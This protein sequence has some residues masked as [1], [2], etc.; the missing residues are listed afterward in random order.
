MMAELWKM[1][2]EAVAEGSAQTTRPG[3]YRVCTFSLIIKKV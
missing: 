1:F 3:V 2:R